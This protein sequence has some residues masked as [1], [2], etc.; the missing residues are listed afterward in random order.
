MYKRQDDHWLTD[1]LTSDAIDFMKRNK[2]EPF[3]VNLN[4]YAPHRPSIA[5][6]EESLSYF[7]NKDGDPNTAQGLQH[8]KEKKEIAAYATMVKSV[9]EN[10]QRIIDFLNQSDLR[11]NTI[12]IFTSDNG[13][14]ELQSCNNNLRGAK[15]NIYEGGMRVPA[16]INWPE[17][18]APTRNDQPISGLD[19]FPTFLDFAK[20]N[21]FAGTLDLSLIHI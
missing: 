20:V 3:F 16:L 1:R 6:N 7:L 2:D 14:N 13:F 4:Y 15:G 11:K 12:L 9:D 10:V 5:R 21:D 19:F 17:T 8:G 18:I